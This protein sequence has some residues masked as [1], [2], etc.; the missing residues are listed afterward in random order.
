MPES[1]IAQKAPFAVEVE[2]GQDYFWCACG[3]SGK[4]PFCDGS[5][6]GSGIT[7]LKYHAEQAK[8]LYFCG[9]KQTR[10]PP[11]CDG[12]HKQL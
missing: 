10:T 9:C 3:R 5:H 2:A 7:P 6:K 12:Q 11:L 1:V 8:T 4:Q